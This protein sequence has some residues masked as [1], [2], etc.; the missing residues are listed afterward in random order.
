MSMHNK[1]LTPL[2]HAGLEAHGLD[3]GTPSQ[4]SDAFRQGIS[5]ALAAA[6][7]EPVDFDRTHQLPA[8]HAAPRYATPVTVDFDGAEGGAVW[9]NDPANDESIAVRGPVAMR[10]LARMLNA[11]ADGYTGPLEAEQ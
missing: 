5:F 1:P 8:W 10:E 11:F 6:S 3:I 2:E 7:G 9:I 4:L